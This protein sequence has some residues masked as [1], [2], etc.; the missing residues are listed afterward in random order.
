MTSLPGLVMCPLDGSTLA[1]S[2]LPLAESLA[3]RWKAELLLV[4]AA[5]PYAPSPPG[6]M[7]SLAMR[8]SELA[9]QEVGPYL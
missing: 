5:E 6:M 1:E 9:G 7:P 8:L 4:R 2:A 3:R